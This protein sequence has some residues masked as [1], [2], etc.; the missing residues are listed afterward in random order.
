MDNLI[1]EGKYVNGQR[2]GRGKEYDG[3][4]KQIFGGEYLND[5]RFKKNKF[6]SCINIWIK[7]Y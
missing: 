4:G 3:N 7:I 6:D 5:K 1:F 2:N